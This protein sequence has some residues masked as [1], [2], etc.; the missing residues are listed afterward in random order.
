[1][2]GLR[3]DPRWKF[4]QESCSCF[5]VLWAPI[6]P[7]ALYNTCPCLKCESCHEGSLSCASAGHTLE[8]TMLLFPF[9]ALLLPMPPMPPPAWPKSNDSISTIPS[10]RLR[11]VVHCSEQPPAFS[12]WKK[13]A[14]TP[15]GVLVRGGEKLPGSPAQRFCHVAW[16]PLPS[17]HLRPWPQPPLRAILHRHA[18]S[19]AL[20]TESTAAPSAIWMDRGRLGAAWGSMMAMSPCRSLGRKWCK[21]NKQRSGSEATEQKKQGWSQWART[22]HHQQAPWMHHGALDGGLS[23]SSGIPA[24]PVSSSHRCGTSEAPGAAP[25]RIG[26]PVT[27]ALITV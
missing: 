23:L 2:D 21:M 5:D 12:K 10:N 16:P 1:M 24:G 19:K 22:N 15:N 11:R 9:G 27:L 14:A 25:L 4:L 7:F 26:L 3:S 8:I 17:L 20:L 6:C 18:A 13:V